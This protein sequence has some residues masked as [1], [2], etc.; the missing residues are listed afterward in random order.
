MSVVPEARRAGL[1]RRAGGAHM[2]VVPEA[3]R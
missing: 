1:R 3:R 2:T